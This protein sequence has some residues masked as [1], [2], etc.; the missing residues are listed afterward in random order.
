M[1]EISLCESVLQVL[2]QQAPVQNYQKVKTVWL[3]IGILS[4]IDIDAL[5]FGFDVVM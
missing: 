3:E 5:R 4:G 1:H 2:E